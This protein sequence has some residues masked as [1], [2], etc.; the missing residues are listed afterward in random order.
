MTENHQCLDG[1]F[2]P[3]VPAAEPAADLDLSVAGVI[4]SGH[5]HAS[6]RNPASRYVGGT[7]QLQ[8]P[9]FLALGLDLGRCFPGTI[10]VS[11]AP[12]TYRIL[13]PAAVLQDVRWFPERRPENFA[14]CRCHVLA[15]PGGVEGYIYQPDPATKTQ[16]YDNPSHLQ[17]LAPFVP[18]LAPGSAV[19]VLVSSV[20][21][22]IVAAP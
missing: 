9:H 5:G 22:E 17:I 7:I 19:T 1:Q 15:A 6:G 18:G 20:E 10:N 8:Y 16:H 2:R 3:F 11:I 13:R 21:V 12:L 4:A 14:F